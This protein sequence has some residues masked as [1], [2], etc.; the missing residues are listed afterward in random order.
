MFCKYCGGDLAFGDLKC[1]RCGREVPAKSDCG[2]FYDLVRED[3]PVQ[4]PTVIM[5]GS[6]TVTKPQTPVG[7]IAGMIAGFAV[8]LVLVLMLFS[9]QDKLT[10]DIEDLRRDIRE[11][12]TEEVTEQTETQEDTTDDMETTGDTDVNAEEEEENTNT[13]VDDIMNGFG[14]SEETTEGTDEESAAA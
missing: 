5:S 6:K 4:A 3:Q 12:K 14:K 13:I 9:A 2:G 1:K 8:L 7:L 11:M 10:Q